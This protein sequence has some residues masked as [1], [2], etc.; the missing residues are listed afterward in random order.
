M[1]RDRSDGLGAT[2]SRHSIVAGLRPTARGAGVAAALVAVVV[3]D[4]ILRNAAL[5]A[6]VV[7]LGLP[8]AAAPWLAVRRARR[9]RAAEVRIMV[10]P[11]LVAVDA[12]C[13]LILQLANLGDA[14]LP[15]LGLDDPAEHSRA[16]SDQRRAP[17][18]AT[19]TRAAA[20]PGRLLRWGGI[21]AHAC[22]STVR[23]IPTRRRG[24]FVIGPL[25]LW[26]HD[27]F[28]LVGVPI[29][30]A[31]PATVVVYPRPAS[32]PLPD[33]YPAGSLTTG[34]PRAG[35]I[36]RQS[37]DPAGEWSGLRPY[38][39]GDRLHLLSWPAEALY[40][41]LLVHEFRPDGQAA[42][43]IVLDD[44]AGVHRREAFEAALS[45][46]HDL[47]VDAGR[48]TLDVELVA[49][50]GDRSS[51]SSLP[52][53]IA[54]HLTFLARAGPSLQAERGARAL[55]GREAGAPTVVV[56]TVTARPSLPPLRG[57]PPVVVVG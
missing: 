23:Q 48:Q 57:D 7:V 33:L 19:R 34:A 43:R 51:G 54:E 27:P 8:L 13:D 3:V 52:D 29:A 50:S 56:T 32:S 28:G 1:R 31:P 10:A 9:S 2:R 30:A 12:P 35:E 6:F 4:A 47:L 18:T 22:A 42:I 44:R 41:A 21:G 45:T 36:E 5:L 53:G 49:L 11:P 46:V 55:S 16:R 39:P 14:V 37:D 15:V 26:A 38:V 25:R 17:A 40:G 24:V 20:A